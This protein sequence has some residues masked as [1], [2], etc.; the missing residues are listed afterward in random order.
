M[1]PSYVRIFESELACVVHETEVN[2]NIETGGSLYGLW[3]ESG[4]PTIMLAVRPGPHA[5][6]QVTQFEQDATAHQAIER[7]LAEFCGVQAVGLW[8]SHHRLGLHELSGGDL[9]RTMRFAARNNRRRFCDVLSFIEDAGH[10][11]ARVAVKPYVYVDAAA[12]KRAPTT[13]VVLPGV[14]PIR[15]ALA[16]SQPVAAELEQFRAALAPPPANWQP[17]YRLARSIEVGMRD[18]DD[19]AV[20]AKRGIVARIMRKPPVAGEIESAE[21]SAHAKPPYGITDLPRFMSEYLE[22]ALRSVPGDVSCELEPYDDVYLRLNLLSPNKTEEHVLELG[23]DGGGPVVIR[24]V[25]QLATEPGSHDM[26]PTGVPVLM[27]PRIDAVLR[28]MTDPNGRR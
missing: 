3:T 8:H 17:R 2:Q 6:H 16:A 22:P 5:I 15:A 19:V 28:A 25:C 18:D 20:P 1:S 9:R 27:K 13:F 7:V 10:S 4:N 12:G 26:L 14:S 21:A 23:W 24:H 11:S